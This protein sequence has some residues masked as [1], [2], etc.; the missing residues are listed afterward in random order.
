MRLLIVLMFLVP[1]STQAIDACGEHSYCPPQG[2]VHVMVSPTISSENQE[3]CDGASFNV[4]FSLKEGRPTDTIIES[5]PVALR[6]AIRQSF[7]KWRFGA[8]EEI[9]NAVESISLNSDCS[10][11]V[12][13]IPW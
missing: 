12:R 9:E 11:K 10:I 8:T 1:V 7:N 3:L 4:R 13:E 2:L 6:P 5:G